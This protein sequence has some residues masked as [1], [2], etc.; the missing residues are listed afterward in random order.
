M[1]SPPGINT[2]QSTPTTT[3]LRILASLPSWFKWPPPDVLAVTPRYKPIYTTDELVDFIV[4]VPKGSVQ[5]SVTLQFGGVESTPF[6]ATVHPG[7]NLISVPKSNIDVASTNVSAVLGSVKAR[8]TF[9]IYQEPTPETSH[10]VRVDYLHGS[11]VPQQPGSSL[12]P[13]SQP[14]FPFG[15]Y[16]GFSSFGEVDP[17]GAMQELKAMGINHVNFVPPYGDGKSIQACIK[18]AQDA[19]VSIQYDM[20]HSYVYTANV[21]TEVNSVK[22]YASLATWYTAD[23]PDGESVAPEPKASTQAYRTIQSLDPHRPVMLVLNLIRDSAAQFS[24]AA[25]ILMTDVYPVGLDSSQC[26]FSPEGGCC[27]CDGCFGDLGTDIRRRLQSYRSQLAEVGKPR[28]PIWMVLQAFSDPKTCW[29]RAPTPEE[30]RLMAYLSIIHGAK[31]LMG[32]IYPQGL[33]QELKASLPGLSAELVLL[34]SKFV[35]GGEQVLEYTDTK[36]QIAAGVWRVDGGESRLYVVANT[37]DM[38]VTL[39]EGEVA[40]IFGQDGAL[41]EGRREM[42]S[43]AVLILTTV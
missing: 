28:M 35:L 26:N 12:T 14:L 15:M 8:A 16:A 22:G 1:H 43:L 27:G 41:V 38:A 10:T 11:L 5:T 2:R 23:E 32:W 39:T 29:S 6:Q 37:G 4:D 40:T 19:G 24:Q 33:T 36:R 13:G 21:T 17:V 25:D 42:E 7:I 18:A 3:I 30:Y 9:A 34:A 31:G 20:R